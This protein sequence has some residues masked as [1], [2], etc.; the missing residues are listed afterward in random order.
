M[1]EIE[2]LTTRFIEKNKIVFRSLHKRETFLSDVKRSLQPIGK[3][4]YRTAQGSAVSDPESYLL[5]M[6]ELGLYSVSKPSV[7][8]KYISPFPFRSESKKSKDKQD[9]EIFL[10]KIIENENIVF[11]SGME[12]KI[13]DVISN[14]FYPV[15]S[16][17]GPALRKI[18]DTEVGSFLGKEPFKLEPLLNNLGFA[19]LVD[20]EQTRYAKLNHRAE[21][22]AK[23]NQMFPGAKTAL[24]EKETDELEKLERRVNIEVKFKAPY[25]NL[26]TIEQEYTKRAELN[27]EDRHSIIAGSRSFMNSFDDLGA[28]RLEA[29]KIEAPNNSQEYSSND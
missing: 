14:H 16:E 12:S 24:I 27:G 1:T 8:E 4:K 11:Q 29:S 22:R 26:T 23:A 28:I 9:C 6:L 10:K 7:L 19:K 25:L 15:N 20:S 18:N 21:L 5:S 17:D 13:I 3:D 2:A